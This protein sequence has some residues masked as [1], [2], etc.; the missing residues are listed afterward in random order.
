[1]NNCLIRRVA[2]S[3]TRNRTGPWV[4]LSNNHHQKVNCF[5]STSS[6]ANHHTTTITS[7]SELLEWYRKLVKR[8]S[9]IESESKRKQVL[10]QLKSEFSKSSLNDWRRKAEE[11]FKFLCMITP[12]VPIS[13]Q[14]QTKAND[15]VTQFVK[16]D[17]EWQAMKS[18]DPEKLQKKDSAYL[19]ETSQPPPSACPPGGCGRCQF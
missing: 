11:S 14:Q 8:A 1:M 16:V 9:Y 2:F 4:V 19:K 15:G 3:T 7:N 13:K 17:G 10:A 18:V 6:A 5:Y 12:K